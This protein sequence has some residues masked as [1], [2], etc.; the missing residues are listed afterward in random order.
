MCGTACSPRFLVA[1]VENA[2]FFVTFEGHPDSRKGRWDGVFSQ[3]VDMKYSTRRLS[4]L[5]QQ[6]ADAHVQHNVVVGP[7]PDADNF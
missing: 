3:A 1:I 6:W 7:G 5:V 4:Y 2:L